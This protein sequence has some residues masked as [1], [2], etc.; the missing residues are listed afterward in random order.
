MGGASLIR[1]RGRANGTE[2]PVGCH[3]WRENEEGV[4]IIPAQNYAGVDTLQLHRKIAKADSLSQI[5]EGL[6][7]LKAAAAGQPSVRWFLGYDADGLPQFCGLPAHQTCPHRMDCPHCGLFIGGEKAKLLSESE[8]V[9]PIW[10]EIPMTQSQQL[11]CEGQREAAERELERLKDVPTPV[12]PS[13]AFLT[14]PL[15]LSE[16]RLDELAKDGTADA[17]A[18]LTMVADALRESLRGYARQGKDGRNVVVKQFCERLAK[19]D[20]LIVEYQRTTGGSPQRDHRDVQEPLNSAS[21]A[22]KQKIP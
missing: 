4:K 2:N 14:N 15:G 16:Q 1:S 12:P 11:L 6:I 10:A 3:L 22:N 19:V 18:Q 17:F 21:R 8:Q 13:A 7:D 20:L 9:Q 5:I